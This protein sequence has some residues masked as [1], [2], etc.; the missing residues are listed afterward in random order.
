ML[1]VRPVLAVPGQWRVSDIGPKSPTEAEFPL[2]RSAVDRLTK[3]AEEAGA[4]TRSAAQIRLRVLPLLSPHQRDDQTPYLNG[5]IKVTQQATWFESY[6]EP[7]KLPAIGIRINSRRNVVSL[8]FPKAEDA[9]HANM[10]V[11]IVFPKGDRRVLALIGDAK[12]LRPLDLGVGAL[13]YDADTGVIRPAPWA[14]T[15]VNAF[16]WAHGQVGL[17]PAGHGFPDRDL[18]SVR[19]TRSLLETDLLRLEA[20][21][22]PDAP[23]YEEVAARRKAFKDGKLIEA[24]APWGV[25][26]VD[27]NGA[28]GPLLLEFR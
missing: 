8:N 7:A 20:K 3:W 11:E 19:A 16:V 17:Y 9:K 1:D 13:R 6:S 2:S 4:S 5:E 22:G 21:Q 26:A 27:S 18:P 25:Q 28:A 14:E 12:Q 10:L 23:P 15:A 24:G